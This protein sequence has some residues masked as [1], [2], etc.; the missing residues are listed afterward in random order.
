MTEPLPFTRPARIT[1]DDSELARVVKASAIQSPHRNIKNVEIAACIP[2]QSLTTFLRSPLRLSADR[3]LEVMEGLER[4]LGLPVDRVA[5]LAGCLPTGETA[6]VNGPRG[7]DGLTQAQATAA[8]NFRVLVGCRPWPSL[9]PDSIVW[10]TWP[11]ALRQA[12]RTLR[13]ADA[14]FAAA[15][16]RPPPPSWTVWRLV[17]IGERPG[18]TSQIRG[19]D[20]AMARLERL[21]LA[22]GL[23]ALAAL[24][25]HGQSNH[26]TA[27]RK[28]PAFPP[29]PQNGGNGSPVL[30]DQSLPDGVAEMAAPQS[31]ESGNNDSNGLFPK[32]GETCSPIPASR[33]RLHF[34]GAFRGGILKS[35]APHPNSGAGALAGGPHCGHPWRDTHPNGGAGDQAPPSAPNDLRCHSSN[36]ARPPHGE[37]NHAD[38]LRPPQAKGKRGR[39]AKETAL[40]L[41]VREAMAARGISSIA[42]LEHRAGLAVDGWREIMRGKVGRNRAIKLHAVDRVASVLKIPPAELAE[43]AGLVEMDRRRIDHGTAETQMRRQAL[44][45]GGD[46]RLCGTALGVLL[47]HDAVEGRMGISQTQHDV[48]QRFADLMARPMLGAPKRPRSELE[49]LAYPGGRHDT[50]LDAMAMQTDIARLAWRALVAGDR[51]A[52]HH[53]PRPSAV[54]WRVAVQGILPRW[55]EPLAT[56]PWPHNDRLEC[57]ALRQ[58]LQVLR[59]H[60]GLNEDHR[61][62]VG[63]LNELRGTA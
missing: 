28:T 61:A 49:R 24:L 4:L 63:A 29:I 1:A 9:E 43:L 44:A 46:P 3:R 56:G 58:G 42:D 27:E 30:A 32:P 19:A 16:V 60:F 37:F 39:P 57:L 52:P 41:R 48:G 59:R 6:G 38:T 55:A 21:A 26:P 14:V 34:K 22:A 5:T 12:W 50:N 33:R 11:V 7:I 47:A 36:P 2:R 8:E 54:V 35:E 18:W 51:E 62:I 15:H 40:S 17:I 10:A 20:D 23:D 25:V 45:A 31:P 53:G 13:T